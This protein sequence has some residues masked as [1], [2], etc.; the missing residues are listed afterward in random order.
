MQ[1]QDKAQ[2]GS[3]QGPP[4][5]EPHCGT[6]VDGCGSPASCKENSE[7]QYPVQT[8]YWLLSERSK[9][10]LRFF[11]AASASPSLASSAQFRVQAGRDGSRR[12]AGLRK[13]QQQAQGPQRRLAPGPPS[14]DGL[15]GTHRVSTARR[16]PAPASQPGPSVVPTTEQQAAQSA[17]FLSKGR[18]WQGEKLSSQALFCFL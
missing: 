13:G 2:A 7:N 6:Q 14:G 11:F 10:V 8:G 1:P 4:E 3:T 12:D 5:L 16:A 9:K 15:P 18:P 17:Y